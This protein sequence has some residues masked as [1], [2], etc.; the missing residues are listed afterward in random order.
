MQA[1][2]GYGMAWALEMWSTAG[3]YMRKKG[4]TYP[5]VDTLGQLPRLFTVIVIDN[6]Q[7]LRKIRFQYFK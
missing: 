3:V 1:D 2:V 6:T 4:I 5:D 7:I